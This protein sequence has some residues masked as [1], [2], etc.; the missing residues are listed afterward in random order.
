MRFCYCM[1]VLT[2]STSYDDAAAPA[3]CAGSDGANL[4]FNVTSPG[5]KFHSTDCDITEGAHFHLKPGGLH[6]R[7]LLQSDYRC[8][9]LDA[10][11]RAWYE[12]TNSV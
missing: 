7:L 2:K 3:M 1:T 11:Q 4:G 5:L 8:S 6:C 10:S 12:H 9:A